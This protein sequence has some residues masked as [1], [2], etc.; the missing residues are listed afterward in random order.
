MFS[1]LIILRTTYTRQLNSAIEHLQT[2]PPAVG[3]VLAAG[4][5][6]VLSALLSVP[7]PGPGNCAGIE[8]HGL[9]LPLCLALVALSLGT[10]PS[11]WCELEAACPHTQSGCSQMGKV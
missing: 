9:T 5:A 3:D 10:A 7:A 1:L 4:D 2:V 6:P 8:L 11:Y